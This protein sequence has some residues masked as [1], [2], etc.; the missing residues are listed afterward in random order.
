MHRDDM[1]LELLPKWQE[2][3]I[4]I[5]ASPL[6]PFTVN[7]QMKAFIERTLPVFMLYFKA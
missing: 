1:A 4:S 2:S 6:Y 3:D 7:A 5:Y